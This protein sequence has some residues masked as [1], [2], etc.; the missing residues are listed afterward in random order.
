MGYLEDVPRNVQYNIHELIP[1]HASARNPVAN[2][3]TTHPKVC[4]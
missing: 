2:T 3:S 4:R 1:R